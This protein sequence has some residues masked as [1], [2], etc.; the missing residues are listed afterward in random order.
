M[1]K[2]QLIKLRKKNKLTQ[3][4]LATR[5]NV[6]P[7][8]ISMYEQGKRQPRQHTLINMANEFGVS[9]NY[10]LDINPQENNKKDHLNEL[11]ESIQ[12]ILSNLEGSSF[13]GYIL[14]EKDIEE[15]VGIIIENIYKEINKKLQK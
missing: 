7:S 5:L 8:T 10:L 15:M 3:A 12:N 1:F 14:Q 6:K 11:S 4:G 9:I 13:H 2:D